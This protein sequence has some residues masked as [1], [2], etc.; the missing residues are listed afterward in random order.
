MY[1]AK[2]SGRSGY[3]FYTRAI[4]DQAM[5]AMR[6]ESRLRSARE[7]GEFSLVYQ[8]VVGAEDGRVRTVETLLRWNNADFGNVPPD[9]FIPLAEERGL[10]TD[11]GA[12]VLDTACR[13]FASWTS[14]LAAPVRLA[15]N[16]SS[17]QLRLPNIVGLVRDALER[18]GPAATT[19]GT[20]NHRT[21]GH[22]RRPGNGRHPQHPDGD[23]NPPV[24]RRL[25]DRLLV[26]QLSETVPLLL[27]EDRPRVR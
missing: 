14:D 4:Y 9:Q 17:R 12:W 15:V 19:P 25:R 1:S 18:S 10:I 16:M 3:H 26:P 2:D 6:M 27:P 24:H 7:N 22:G 13:E 11:I 21:R 8:P 20:R 5:T 23:G